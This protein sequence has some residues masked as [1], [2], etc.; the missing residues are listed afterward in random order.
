MAGCGEVLCKPCTI[1]CKGLKICWLWCFLDPISLGILR[2]DCVLLLDS[3]ALLQN[4]PIF[5]DGYFIENIPQFEIV[6]A[7]GSE[8][9]AA[10]ETSLIASETLSSPLNLAF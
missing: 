8:R 3:T 6:S 4:Q 5:Q 10:L 7:E 1:L 9:T 2:D